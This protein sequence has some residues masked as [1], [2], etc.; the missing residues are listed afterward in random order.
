MPVRTGGRL[1][2]VC[3]GE[4]VDVVACAGQGRHREGKLGREQGQRA[5]AKAVE[6]GRLRRQAREQAVVQLALRACRGGAAAT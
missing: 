6:V 3:P 4:E 2:G 1:A 5:V